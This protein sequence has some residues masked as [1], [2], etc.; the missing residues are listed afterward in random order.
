MDAYVLPFLMEIII[1]LN[2]NITNW[3]REVLNGFCGE[4]VDADLRAKIIY[5]I[6]TLNTLSNSLEKCLT[7][8][9]FNNY[10]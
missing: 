4:K 3:F 8:K 10:I 7:S 2:G 5:R 6:K 9:I 1:E